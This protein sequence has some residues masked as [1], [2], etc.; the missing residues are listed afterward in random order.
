MMKC[1]NPYLPESQ[2][3]PFTGRLIII[4]RLQIVRECLVEEIRRRYGLLDLRQASCTENATAMS[5][6]THDLLV[7]DASHSDSDLGAD[8]LRAA[9][10]QTPIILLMLDGVANIGIADTVKLPPSLDALLFMIGAA[11]GLQA[12]SQESS[13]TTG[14]ERASEWHYLTPREQEV[15][16]GVM[17]G[18][19]NKLIAAEL[20]LSENTI[21]MHLTQIMRKLK[22]T[23][24]TQVVLLLRSKPEPSPL[25][26]SPL[27]RAPA[28]AKEQLS[29]QF[30]RPRSLSPPVNLPHQTDGFAPRRGM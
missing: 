19:A 15:A 8:S 4:S 23:N 29:R 26:A 7:V 10:P 3:P 16:H 1:S 27:P 18:K 6:E 28:H 21:K 5:P 14:E 12:R 22:V 2:K 20:A 9:F 17:E 13:K 30:E 11:C 24:R 25:P